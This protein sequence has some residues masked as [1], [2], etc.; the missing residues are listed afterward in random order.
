MEAKVTHAK[1]SQG[2]VRLILFKDRGKIQKV[3]DKCTRVALVHDFS[4]IEN[5]RMKEKKREIVKKLRCVIR[6]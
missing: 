2:Y 1:L 3:M 5:R 4:S 6:R